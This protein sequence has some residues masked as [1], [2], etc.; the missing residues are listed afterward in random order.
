[1]EITVAKSAGF[2]FGVKRAIDIAK[3][4]TLLNDNVYSIGSIVHNKFVNDELK[5]LGLKFAESISEIP[6]GSKVIIRAHGVTPEELA[7]CRERNLDIIDTTC[8]NVKKIHNI[9]DEYSKLGYRII[10]IGDKNHPEI[11]G[12][13]KR[14]TDY[15]VIKDVSELEYEY[16]DKICVVSQT[17]MNIEKNNEIISNIKKRANE[18]IV[19]D[20]VCNATEERQ[21]ELKSLAKDADYVIV[22]GDKASANSNRLYEIA[23]NICNSQFIEN[24][25][26]LCL[27]FF[28]NSCKIVVMAGAST[29]KELI[30]QVVN[31]LNTLYEGMDRT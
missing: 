25:D 6:F 20:T 3:N 9:V 11:I 21:N 5:G 17:T 12:I 15:V 31:K 13:S 4:S 29:P 22:I 23:K 27:K 28:D 2:C 30:S 10:I 8:P 18:V 16:L 19:F 1:M 26:E 14:A 24:V 7:N